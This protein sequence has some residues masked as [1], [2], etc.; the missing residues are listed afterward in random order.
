MSSSVLS[1]D[2]QQRSFTRLETQC[3][4]AITNALAWYTFIYLL[5]VHKVL[6]PALF[7]RR[8]L[9]M[10]LANLLFNLAIRKGES[11]MVN[12]S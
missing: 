6:S 4:S 12:S 10:L 9:L 8:L 2:G 11:R 7:G 3:F 5:L 1:I